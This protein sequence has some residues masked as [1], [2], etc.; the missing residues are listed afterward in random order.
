MGDTSRMNAMVM[1]LILVLLG[2][3]L[4]SAHC[5]GRPLNRVESTIRNYTIKT[6]HTLA[7]VMSESASNSSKVVTIF[8][9]EERRRGVT[10]YCCNT[11]QPKRCF[12][13]WA[14]CRANCRRCA[15]K[16]PSSQPLPSNNTYES[17]SVG[18]TA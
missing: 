8:C 9:V 15:P 11:Y 16:C 2:C 12:N 14:D 13:S 1:L 3:F 5:G 6:N 7:N 17:M 4:G 18:E 10:C